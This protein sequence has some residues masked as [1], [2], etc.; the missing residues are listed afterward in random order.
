M[1]TINTDVLIIG[2]GP[3]GLTNAALLAREGIDCIALNRLGHTSPTPRAHITNQRCMEVFRDL[4]CEDRL[5]NVAIPKELMGEHVI[6]STLAG[7]EYGR[8][9]TWGNSPLKY[10]SHELASPSRLCDIPQDRMEPLQ[11]DVAQ[12]LGAKLRYH[13][14][15]VS[16]EQDDDGVTTTVHDSLL[17]KTYQIRS[18]YMIGADGARSKVAEHAGLPFE[19]QMGLVG[20][21]NIVFQADLSRYFEHRPGVIYMMIQTEGQGVSGVPLGGLRMANDWD[22]FVAY[23]GW[24]MNQPAPELTEEAGKEVIE[25]LIGAE[26]P[27]L[28]IEDMGLWT[29]NDMYATTNYKGRVFCMGDAVH[30]HPPLNGLGTNTCMQDSINLCWKMA[31]VL[32]GQA[33][34][35]LLDTYNSERVPVARQI[36][37]RANK[38]QFNIPNIFDAMNIIDPSLTSEQKL[39]NIAK[40]KEDTS[41][42]VDLRK[43]I[44]DAFNEQLFGFD[45]HGV[46]VNIRYSSSEAIVSDGTP[47]P[48]WKQ[49]KEMFYQASSRPGAHVPHAWL[50]ERSTGKRISTLDLCGKGQ[51]TVLTGISGEKT[52]TQAVDQIRSE[53]GVDVRL[54]VIGP[55]RTY[56][57]AYSYYAQQS[58]VEESGALLI[59]PDFYV[60]FRANEANPAAADDLVAGMKKILGRA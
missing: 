8:I 38:S 3:T 15:Y 10:A 43:Q 19:G 36:V 42:A 39:R 24:D 6:C 22:R 17:D 52:W 58:E 12:K 1:K 7:E 18:K 34:P 40:R 47:E 27:D 55:G 41:D 20:G 46:E 49:D 44:T 50:V 16:H 31:M 21:F 4:E 37:K 54:H 23:W 45:T 57:D 48:E 59:R 32:K 29:V 11:Q 28:K 56:E 30:R 26:L 35:S 5:V 53:L 33:T 2:G 13:T 51:F 9:E 14:E 60:A 25:K